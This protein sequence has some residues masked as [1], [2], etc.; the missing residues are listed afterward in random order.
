MNTGSHRINPFDRSTITN[1][2]SSTHLNSDDNNSTT[3]DPSLGR[4]FWF[5]FI[6]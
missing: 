5:R 6:K 2:M 4:S 3:N 1:D